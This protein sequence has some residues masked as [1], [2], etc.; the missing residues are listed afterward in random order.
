MPTITELYQERCTKTDDDRYIPT[1]WNPPAIKREP[2]TL[3]GDAN[4]PCHPNWGVHEVIG[5]ILALGLELELPVGEFVNEHLNDV[6]NDALKLLLK[7]NVADEA[8]H[9]RGFELAVAAYPL[10][11]ESTQGAKY[12]SS[13]WHD[14]QDPP[15]LL[16]AALEIGVF[17]SSLAALRLFGG[18]SLALMAD[19]IARDEYRH[20]SVN[21]MLVNMSGLNFDYVEGLISETIRW[22]FGGLIIPSEHLGI[23]VNRE[24]FIESAIQLIRFGE[25][26][27]LDDL[28]NYANHLLPFEISNNRLY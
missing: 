20:A 11:A 9:Y 19:G 25:S 26:K 7:S 4:K 13:L 23:V 28:V 3:R 14:R 15:I 24:F 10:T 2:Y 17:L 18:S 8:R 5:R 27:Q 12:I 16:A 22:I 1:F 6:E 21:R